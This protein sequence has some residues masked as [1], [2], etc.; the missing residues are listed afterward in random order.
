MRH[1]RLDRVIGPLVWGLLPLIAA[2]GCLSYHPQPLDTAAHPAEYRARRLDDTLV[3]NYLQ[4]VVG[5]VPSNQWDDVQLALSALLF[6]PE[7]AS[8]RA[9]WHAAQAAEITA[10]ARPPGGF[11]ADLERAVSGTGG[12]S[13]WVVSLAGLFTVELG[14]KRGARLLRARASATVAESELRGTTWRIV[15]DV[16]VAASL[17]A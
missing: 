16:R 11:Q 12:S 2:A 10:G 3:R 17:A 8:A 1:F 14:G 4:R 13:P 6:R 7:L 5:T 9:R 15:Q